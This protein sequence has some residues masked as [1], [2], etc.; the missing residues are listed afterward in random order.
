MTDLEAEL[1]RIHREE[2][3]AVVASLVRR[4]GGIDI[5]EDAASE[6]LV[7]ALEHWPSAGASSRHLPLVAADQ[8]RRTRPRTDSASKRS[9]GSPLPL[10]LARL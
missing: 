1:T 9:T 3:A 4:F 10:R 7:A 6:A 8:A 5:A 2:Y